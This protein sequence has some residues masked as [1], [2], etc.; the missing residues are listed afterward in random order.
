MSQKQ[1]FMLKDWTKKCERHCKIGLDGYLF[2]SASKF[3]L[4]KQNLRKPARRP[5][6]FL[7]P[8]TYYS[9]QYDCF[10]F[11]WGFLPPAEG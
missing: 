5:A 9:F 11:F 10:C 3:P 1:D 4:K 6:C 2:R 8:Y 7:A